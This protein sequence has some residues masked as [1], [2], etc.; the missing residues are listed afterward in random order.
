MLSIVLLFPVPLHP[1]LTDAN[2]SQ[3]INYLR[4]LTNDDLK[5][6]GIHLGLTLSRLSNVSAESLCHSMVNSWLRED[7]F[8]MAHAPPTWDSLANA[9]ETIRMNGLAFKIRK[10]WYYEIL[11]ASYIISCCYFADFQLLSA[12]TS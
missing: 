4:D 7:D 8:V 9:L 1:V 11:A 10:G 3:I 6:L 12:T 5:K 2:Y